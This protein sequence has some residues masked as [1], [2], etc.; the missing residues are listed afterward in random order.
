[1]KRYEFR[2]SP[3]KIFSALP[4]HNNFGWPL[5]LRLDR[6][7]TLLWPGRLVPATIAT[8]SVSFSGKFDSRQTS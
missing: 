7:R 2:S 8:E 3:L 5:A 4:I 6:R 1:M